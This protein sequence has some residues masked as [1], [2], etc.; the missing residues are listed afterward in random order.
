MHHFFVAVEEVAGDTE[1]F[2]VL[3]FDAFD[4]FFDEEIDIAVGIGHEDRGVG[5]DDELGMVADEVVDAGEDAHLAGGRQ[6]G[7]GFVE[8][9]NALAAE[10][11]QQ[12]G[13]EG[14]AVGLLVQAFA[15]VRSKQP[16]AK[17]LFVEI[18]DFSSHG[19]NAFGAEKKSVHRAMRRALE[20]EETME[21]GV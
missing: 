9:V 11:M 10:A 21:L 6:G 2:G 8:D 17:R 15:A 16:A 13:K 14:F 4:S 1:V 5:G 20:R 12:E 7:F 19:V 18:L 3:V